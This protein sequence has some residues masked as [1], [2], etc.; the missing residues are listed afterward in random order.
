VTTSFTR[1]KIEHVATASPATKWA[2]AET[3][4]PHRRFPAIDQVAIAIT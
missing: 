4:N 2:T 1:I 3:Y